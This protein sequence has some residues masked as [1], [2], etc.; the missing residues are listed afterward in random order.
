MAIK[1]LDDGRYELD[2][3]TGG[4][5]SKRVR[6]IF[7]RKADAVAYERYMLG[8]IERK[9]W[10]PASRVDRR[11]LSEIRAA[12]WL[13]HGQTLKNG[14]I[15]NR[16]LLKTIAALDDPGVHEL[17]KRMLVLHRNRRLAQG[18]SAATIN[19]D[20]YRLSG[21]FSALIRL[22][23]YT[24][25]NPVR[26]LPPLTE[27][28]PGM[29]FLTTEEISRLLEA[30]KGD[31][32]LVALLCLSTGGRW[33]EVVGMKSHQ[34]LKE[35][36]VFTETKNGK[37]RVVPV[38]AEL[39]KEVRCNHAGELFRVDYEVFCRKLRKVKPDLPKGQ[40]THVL[41]HTFAS[42]FMMNGGNIIALQQIL[43]HATIQ[44]TMAYAHLAPDY[45]Q[46]AVTLNPL[47]GG[48]RV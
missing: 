17:N 12:W 2:T 45:L 35:R 10:D 20:L 36:V 24:G 47:K 1:K 28:N 48:L 42:H 7:N 3:R 21:M 22:D 43:G 34:L 29:T 40:A 8:K 41:R 26:G 15:E 46:N 33:S 37:D 5:G 14:E 11:P 39:E 19:R 13:Y 4:R 30:L 32:R 16:H 31:Y 9:E 38:S 44:Q 25:V 6:K 18:V 23:E 27:K